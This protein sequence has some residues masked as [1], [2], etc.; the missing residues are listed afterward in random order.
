MNKTREV[1]IRLSELAFRKLVAI[2]KV[3]GKSKTGLL[4]DL[5]LLEYEKNKKYEAWFDADLRDRE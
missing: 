4:R 3:T 1:T 2:C 5:I